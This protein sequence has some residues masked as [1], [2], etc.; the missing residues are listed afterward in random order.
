MSSQPSRIAFFG[1]TFDPIHNGHLEIASKARASVDLDEV[2]FIPCRRSPHKLQGPNVSDPDR[3]DLLEAATETIDWARVDPYELKKPPPSYSYE[4]ISSLKKTYPTGTD[5][6]FLLGL[7]QWQSLPQWK[8]PDLLAREVT[9]IV[10]GREGSGKPREGYKALF[11]ENAHPASSSAIRT[12]IASG[13]TPSWLPPAVL[14]LIEKRDL[15]R[16]T[17]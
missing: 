11:L 4:T 5:F 1:G 16:S 14:A 3:L 17:H 2:V 12:A 15:Y 9:F 6:Y 13:Q 10:V 8:N 7:D